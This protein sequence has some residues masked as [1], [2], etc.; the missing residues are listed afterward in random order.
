MNAFTKKSTLGTVVACILIAAVAGQAAGAHQQKAGA[1]RAFTVKD[2]A[3]MRLV[4]S[5]GNTKTEI[6]RASGTLPG[7][8]HGTVTAMGTT[9]RFIFVFDVSGGAVTGHGSGQV[10]IGSSGYA[11]FSAS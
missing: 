10:H 2:T 5:N 6:G 4:H 7:T 1:A 11:S 3:N 8:V 9:G